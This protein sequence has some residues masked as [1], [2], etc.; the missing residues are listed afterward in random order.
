[1]RIQMWWFYFLQ[2]LMFKVRF[3]WFIIGCSRERRNPNGSYYSLDDWPLISLILANEAK[4][5]DYTKQLLVSP[6]LLWS[7]QHPLQDRLLV[8]ALGHSIVWHYRI[9]RCPLLLRYSAN[10]EEGLP[11][12]AEIIMS[13]LHLAQQTNHLWMTAILHLSHLPN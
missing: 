11:D 9:Y 6:L 12:A 1:M 10:K 3:S 13:W 2:V 7:N 4:P 8:L 5:F